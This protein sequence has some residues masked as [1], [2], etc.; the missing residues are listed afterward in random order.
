MEKGGDERIENVLHWFSYV[1][2]IEHER[3]TK[4]LYVREFTGCSLPGQ[5]REE[6]VD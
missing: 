3:I 5:P 6:E 2:R 4:R 1:E